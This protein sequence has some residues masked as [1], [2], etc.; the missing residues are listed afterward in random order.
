MDKKEWKCT[1]CGASE[2]ILAG[3]SNVFVH[4]GIISNKQSP[5]ENEI[6]T[7]CGTIVRSYAIKP[8]NLKK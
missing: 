1:H 5:V 4:T 6:C 3:Q 8:E 2:Y 7:R